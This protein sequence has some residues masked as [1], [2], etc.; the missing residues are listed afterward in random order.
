MN[1]GTLF[2]FDFTPNALKSPEAE[3]QIK[4]QIMGKLPLLAKGILERGKKVN[5]ILTYRIGDYLTLLKESKLAYELGLYSSAISMVGITAE[6]FAI[7]LSGRLRFR[8]NK[9]PIRRNELFPNT[10]F[11]QY[12]RLMIL[13]KAGLISDKMFNKLDKIRDIRNKY[14]HPKN[15]G[16]PEKDSIKALNLMIE[17]L[18]SDFSEKYEIVE[19]KIVLKD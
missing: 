11:N 4:K 7:E 12:K 10:R 9:T 2:Y 1:K 17:C 15:K 6:R 13:R 19:G 5:P 18:Q 14:V 16:N 8:V 3:K